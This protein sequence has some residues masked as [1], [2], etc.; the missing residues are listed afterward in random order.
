MNSCLLRNTQITHHHI[1]WIFNMILISS[2]IV[3]TSQPTGWSP[4]SSLTHS[5]GFRPSIVIVRR[6]SHKLAWICQNCSRCSS[7]FWK[8]L[9]RRLQHLNTTIYTT[10]FSHHLRYFPLNKTRSSV[11]LTQQICESGLKFNNFNRKGINIGIHKKKR[12]KSKQYWFK[13]LLRPSVK[14]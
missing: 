4:T 12:E 1:I 10:W 6:K 8:S 9:K 5:I 11:I 13:T 2:G 14:I 3:G 7:C